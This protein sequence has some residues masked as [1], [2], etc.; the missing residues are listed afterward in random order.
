MKIVTSNRLIFRILTKEDVSQRY[1]GWLNDPEVNQFLETRFLE[2]SLETCVQFVTQMQSDSSSFLFGIFNKE[3]NMHI[4][5]IKL[6]FINSRHSIGQL[7]LFIGEKS[8]WG[9]GF[10]TESIQTITQWGFNELDLERVEAGCYDN[11]M[12]S[13]RAFLK[14]G[15]AVEGFFK[16]SVVFKNKRIG[17]FWLGITK[18]D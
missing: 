9:K 2:Q 5:N 3:T 8:E 18:N 4:G 11:N 10:A 14:A 17:S 15:Y 7:S 16:S 12:G 13:L 6:G 1:V